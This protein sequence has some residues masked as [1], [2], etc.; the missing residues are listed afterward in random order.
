MAK[1]YIA[2]TIL[3]L[4]YLFIP[5]EAQHFFIYVGVLSVLINQIFQ[6]ENKK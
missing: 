1:Y 3:V 2:F 6:H 5:E 4:L